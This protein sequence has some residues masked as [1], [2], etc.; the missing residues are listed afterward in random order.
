MAPSTLDRREAAWLDR[1]ARRWTDAGLLTESQA[2]AIRQFEHAGEPVPASQLTVVAEVAA[3]LAGVVT[4]AGGAAIIGPNWDRLGL[5]GQAVVALAIG[6]VGL[7]GGGWL[8]H[9]GD[10][11]MTRL[12]TF[13][14]VVGTGGVALLFGAVVNEIDPSDDAWFPTVIGV[15]VLAI[16]GV[17][18]RNLDRPLQLATAALGAGLVGG[19]IFALTEVSMWIA[20]PVVWTAS[21]VFGIFAAGGRLRPRLVGL[22]LAAVGMMVG[23]FALMS[24]SER[25]GS[26]MA[27]LSAAIIVTFALV[28]Q[29]WPL[30]TVGVVS[31]FVAI[32]SLL[33]NVLH[34]TPAQ[35]AA[36]GLG[37][38]VIAMVAVRAQ[39]SSRAG[40]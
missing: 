4:F 11:G 35:L 10:V 8:V 20:S 23:S 9:Q 16:G 6:L 7:V 36:V 24:A 29:S 17:L 25:S 26:F 15:P 37:L 27:V 32:T 18:W 2:A 39:R 28:D 12:G 34:G 30:V 13:L 3:Y 40:P 1:H 19:G 22:I 5:A 38:I 14:W 21:I 33:Q 31:F